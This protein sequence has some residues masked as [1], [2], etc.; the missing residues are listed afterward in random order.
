[1][2]NHMYEDPQNNLASK[3]KK[4]GLDEKD[5]TFIKE[6][7]AGPFGDGNDVRLLIIDFIYTKYKMEQIV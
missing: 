5:R 3:F 7:I 1:M 6:Q 4:F 2:F